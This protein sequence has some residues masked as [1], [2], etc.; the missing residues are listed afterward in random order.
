MDEICIGDIIA[1]DFEGDPLTITQLCGPGSLVL[2]GQGS[3]EICFVPTSVDSVYEFCIQVTDGCH[4]RTETFFFTVFPSPNCGLVA[5]TAIVGPG[6]TFT[7][8]DTGSSGPFPPSGAI[9]PCSPVGQ[10][11]PVSI[12]T[13]SFAPVAG[14]DILI[15]YDASAVA[16]LFADPGSAIT[17]WEF[18]TFNNG[19]FASC[20]VACPKGL[21]RLVAIGDVNDG[22]NHPPP[23]A[24]DVNGELVKITFLISQDQNLSSQLIPVSFL[25]LD[26]GDNAYSNPSG[27]ELYLNSRI[28][29]NNGTLIGDESDDIGFPESSRPPRLG[30]PDACLVP[31]AKFQPARSTD[32]YNGGICIIPKDPDNDRGDLNLNGI[33]YEVAD[34]VTYTNYF[35]VGLLAFKLDILRQTAASDVNADGQTL[36]IADLVFLIRVLIGDQDPIPKVV[37]GGAGGAGATVSV[38]RNINSY[39]VIADVNMNIGGAVFTFEFD[40]AAPESISLASGASNM[41]LRYRIEDGRIRALIFERAEGAHGAYIASGRTNLL[42]IH[43]PENYEGEVRLL[44]AELADERGWSVINARIESGLLPKSFDLGQN[45]PNPFNPV[46]KIEL[47]LPQATQWTLTV[48]NMLGQRVR[49]FDGEAEAGVL[50]VIWDGRNDKGRA[51]ASG[52]YLYQVKAGAFAQTKKM[53]LLK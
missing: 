41:D 32:F 13:E 38:S 3:A 43:L 5:R 9:P 28:F 34:A 46:T 8:P 4:T 47:A 22:V 11:A 52:V 49:R 2:I 33:S 51:V 16:F 36:T 39:S 19:P 18:F 15:S 1:T 29:S 35:I 50:S 45:Y 26:C 53:M 21:L 7:F 27:D 25:W 40:G 48:Y 42:T 31:G 14:F 6:S 37:P 30:A 23:G 24:F 44:G 10:E 20:G 17:D 12:I